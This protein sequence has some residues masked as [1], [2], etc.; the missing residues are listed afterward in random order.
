MR[1]VLIGKHLHSVVWEENELDNPLFERL[2]RA[3]N[4]LL[5]ISQGKVSKTTTVTK[6]NIELILIPANSFFDYIQFIFSACKEFSIRKKNTDWQVIGASEPLGGGIAATILQLWYKIPFIAMVQGDLLDLP[7]SHFN[8]FKRFL[9]KSLTLFVSKRADATR[10]VSKKIRDGLIQHGLEPEKVFL[11]RNRVNLDRFNPKKLKHKRKENRTLLGWQ[12]SQILAYAGALTEEKGIFEFVTGGKKL[13]QK[14]EHLC[15]LIIGDGIEK[16]WS[17]DELS[18][19]KDRVHFT[20]FVPHNKIH[21]WLCVADIFSF[22]SHHEGMPRV[23]L[24]YMAMSKPVIS[25]AVGGVS[26]VIEHGTSGLIIEK[27]NVPD[28]VE[29]ADLI[30]NKMIDGSALGKNSRRIVETH[31]DLETTIAEQIKLY[32]KIANAKKR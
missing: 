3:S 25:T 11:L 26:E 24:E 9:L 29:K 8:P 10:T 14:H 32:K 18:Q 5:I 16:E 1:L 7:V 13:L 17:V 23:V 4:K 30:L 12:S 21:E 22:N 15:L 28:F 2:G 31:H 19:F 20:G 6:L 27:G